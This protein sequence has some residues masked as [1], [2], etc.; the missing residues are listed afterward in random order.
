MNKTFSPPTTIQSSLNFI[1][2]LQLANGGFASF[3]GEEAT[4]HA[5]AWGILM[6]SAFHGDRNACTQG[7]SFLASQQTE[8]GRIG[9]TPDHPEASWP[10]PLA[11]LAWMGD[12]TFQEAQG[13]A[14]HFLLNFTG[15]H[16]PNPDPHIVGHDTAI[17]GWPWI[18]HTHSWVIPT[19][20]TIMA[21]RTAGQEN[22]ER[23]LEGQD[24][25]LNRQ[26]DQGGWNYGSTK[27]FGRPTPPLPESTAVALHA[28]AGHVPQQQIAHSLEYLIGELPRLKTPL[29]LGWSLLALGAWGDKPSQSAK[30]ILESLQLQQKYGPY[31][32]PSLAL[33]ALAEQA[34]SGLTLALKS[35]RSH[36]RPFPDEIRKGTI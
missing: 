34:P 6:L 16:F 36:P 17:R 21:L 8:D 22:H 15:Y 30:W 10:T 19:A 25:L 33:L 35:S 27:V 7:R 32:L 26:L 23:V 5:T 14:T 2:S 24:M 9:I 31:A 4:S 13:K 20:L 18:A 1:S 28:L 29:S 11:L 12:S 3:P